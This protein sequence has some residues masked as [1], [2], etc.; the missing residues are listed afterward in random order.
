MKSKRLLASA[1][2]GLAFLCL[3]FP[4]GAAATEFAAGGYPAVITG[5][6]EGSHSFS[7][8]EGKVSVSCSAATFSGEISKGT[9]ELSLSPSYS[10]CT[11]SGLAV[12]ISNN[13]CTYKI[14]S[15]EEISEHHLTSTV[16]LV[17]PSEKTL[18]LKS[19]AVECEVQI[20]GQTGLKSG[21]YE[22]KPEPEPGTVGMSLPVSGIK[23]NKTKDAG[24]LC[25]L[26]GTG[27]KTDGKYSGKALLKGTSGGEAVDFQDGIISITV[28]SEIQFKAEK[29]EKKLT[30]SNSG[31]TQWRVK[32][33]IFEPG[34][35]Q[36]KMTDICPKAKNALTGGLSC[37]EEVV[38]E[39]VGTRPV[40]I[41]YT[42]GAVEVTLKC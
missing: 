39:K 29:E 16:D 7:F 8:D 3:L 38:C 9:T 20:A 18:V 19:T 10:S 28:P 34:S 33:Y 12:S 6:G 42:Y 22:S 32:I 17:C 31:N 13:G 40:R 26:N 2:F 4:A 27:V 15:G 24:F 5:E 37:T 1:I 23:Y 36:F 35:G 11:M 30:I 41:V 14:R 25:P 21:E